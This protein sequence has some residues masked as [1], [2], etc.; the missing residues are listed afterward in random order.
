[1][2][3]PAAIDQLETLGEQLGASGDADLAP[4][5]DVVRIAREGIDQGAGRATGW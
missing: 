4:P 1:V 5:Q 3:R 2:Y